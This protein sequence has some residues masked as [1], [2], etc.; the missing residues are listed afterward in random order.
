MKVKLSIAAAI[1]VIAGAVAGCNTTE[2]PAAAPGSTV[3]TSRA[4][5]PGGIAIVSTPAPSAGS[6]AATAQASPVTASSTENGSGHGLC[7]DL[8]SALA[9]SAVVSLAPQLPG[10]QWV[11]QAA[12]DDP[13]AAG[14]SGV[15]S[16]LTVKGPGIHPVT[17]ILFFTGGT[18]LGTATAQPY[19][20][21]TVLGKTRD[22]VSVQYKWPEPQDPLCCPT[23]TSTVTFTL[24]GTTVTAQGQ[25]PPN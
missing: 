24:N 10:D 12:S 17:H 13:I 3:V 7:L 15:L 19:A 16:W 14:C 8:N 5:S 22:T 4:P 21:T 2:Q 6:G 20:Y 9:H 11:V 25:F 23:G 1:A 18:Y